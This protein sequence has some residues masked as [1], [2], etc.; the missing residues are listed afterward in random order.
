MRDEPYRWAAIEGLF[1]AE[2]AAALADSFPRDK[3]RDVA[4][5]DGEKGYRYAARSLIHMGAS[6]PSHP[7]G[8]DPL[9]LALAE[10]LLSPEYRDA[11]AAASGL[12]LASAE[13]E[14][15]VIH[16]G[17]GAW[18]GPHVDLEEKILTHILYFNSDWDPCDG[19]CLNI[20]RSRD[21]DDKVAEIVPLVG[22]SS[23]VVRSDRSWHSVSPVSRGCTTSRR[24]LNVIFHLP[25][26]VSTMW[27]TRARV[28]LRDYAPAG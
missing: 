28:R 26:S 6:A 21:P 17:A 3:F 22:N 1:A 12:D 13:M 8:L 27:P 7:R 24:S 11:L 10:D 14:A 15:N 4:G 18:L 20:L 19:G 2:D 5:Y 25:G 23:L 16:Y 9:W